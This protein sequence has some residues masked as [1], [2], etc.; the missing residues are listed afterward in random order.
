MIIVV[1]SWLELSTLIS[2]IDKL[3]H[4]PE[5]TLYTSPPHSSRAFS[6]VHL[7][8][9]RRLHYNDVVLPVKTIVASFCGARLEGQST[10][11]Q[12]EIP[13]RGELVDLPIPMMKETLIK[14]DDFLDLCKKN[15]GE[16]APIYDV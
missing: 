10:G 3:S 13:A 8:R 9:Q 5:K 11:C 2:S 4:T 1:W 16:Q 6:R 15:K 7:G 14:I 12:S